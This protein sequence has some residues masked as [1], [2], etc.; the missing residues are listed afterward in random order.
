M[1]KVIIMSEETYNPDSYADY[2]ENEYYHH[3]DKGCQIEMTI[4]NGTRKGEPALPG[5]IKKCLT[6]NCICS[7]TGWEKGFYLGKNSAINYCKCGKEISQNKHFCKDCIKIK[8]QE[9][10]KQELEKRRY[11][12]QLKKSNKFAI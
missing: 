3:S 9:T 6:H 4:A 8:R 11:L 2:L 1:R 12:T 7:K 10:I 5:V